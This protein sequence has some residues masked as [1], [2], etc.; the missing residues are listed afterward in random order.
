MVLVTHAIVGAAI[1]NVMPNHPILGFSVAFLSHYLLDAIPHAEYDISGLVDS[2][3]KSLFKL[4]KRGMMHIFIIGADFLAGIAL[5]IFFFARND[6]RLY[7]TL[8]GLIGGILPDFLQFIY[9]KYKRQPWKFFQ[10]LHDFFHAKENLQNR[11]V[12]NFMMHTAPIFLFVL[13][14][15]LF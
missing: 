14:Y 1:A 12:M 9:L 8:L 6:Q 2:K 10:K 11:Q 15:L 13:A 7:I 4:N 3:N 5:S